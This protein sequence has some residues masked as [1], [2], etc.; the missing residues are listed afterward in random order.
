MYVLVVPGRSGSSCGADWGSGR[1][2]CL[3]DVVVRD[4]RIVVPFGLL[5]LGVLDLLGV[6]ADRTLVVQPKRVGELVL[7]AAEGVL[8]FVFVFAGLVPGEVRAVAGLGSWIECYR[9]AAHRAVLIARAGEARGLRAACTVQIVI[10]I[11]G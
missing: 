9:Q 1:C 4:L 11:N 7:G 6:A 2:F 8:G 3:F 5:A 10:H